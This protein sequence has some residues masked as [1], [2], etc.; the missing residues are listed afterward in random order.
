MRSIINNT[1]LLTRYYFFSL[2][3]L[4]ILWGI[5]ALL[6]IQFVNIVFFITTFVWH[7]TLLTPGIREKILS[8]GQRYSFLS[9]IVRINHY[10]QL[11]INLKNIPFASSII[12]AISPLVFTLILLVFGGTGNLMFSLMGSVCFEAF[13][14]FLKPWIT[15]ISPLSDRDDSETPPAIPTEEKPL[16]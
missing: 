11:F 9:V 5:L 4:M 16:E 10:L 13:Y 14:H 12:R 1:S 6:P 15:E 8:S 2:I 3:T 7:F